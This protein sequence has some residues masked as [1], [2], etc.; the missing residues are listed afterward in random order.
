MNGIFANNPPQ[1]TITLESIRS[2]ID[3]LKKLACPPGRAIYIR[4]DAWPSIREELESRCIVREEHGFYP[5]GRCGS[6]LGV[7]LIVTKAPLARPWM[8]DYEMGIGEP[9]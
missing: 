9:R 7:E 4:E 8:W 3:E 6:I 1:P 2:A 5:T